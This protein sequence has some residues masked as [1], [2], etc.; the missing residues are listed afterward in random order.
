MFLISI[1]QLDKFGL[2]CKTENGKIKVS[3]CSLVVLK[4]E[5]KNGLYELIGKTMI[6]KSGSSLVVKEDK[7]ILWHNRMGHISNKGLQDLKKH[8]LF[9]EDQV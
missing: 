9:K 7:S 3:R 4:A 1:G 2:S 6:G 8:G 5:M